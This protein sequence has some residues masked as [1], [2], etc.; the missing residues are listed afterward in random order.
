MAGIHTS[1]HEPQNAAKGAEIRTPRDVAYVIF[2][3]LNAMLVVFLCVLIPVVAYALLSGNTYVSG[4]KVLVRG[5]PES[6]ALASAADAVR[7]GGGARLQEM[8]SELEIMKSRELH[9]QVV[10]GLAGNEDRSPAQLEKA[11]RKLQKKL[12]IELLEDTHVIEVGYQGDDPEHVYTVVSALIDQFFAKHLEVHRTPGAKRFFEE[13]KTE[14]A[15]R[16]KAADQALLEARSETGITDVASQR[17]A[18]LERL[19]AR[20]SELETA[21]GN[22]QALAASEKAVSEL[23]GELPE[24]VVVSSASG[25]ASVPAERLRERLVELK[26][27]EQELA[28]RYHEDTFIVRNMREQIEDVESL[29]DREWQDRREVTQGLNEN[30]RALELSLLNLAS[31]QRALESRI[32][33]LDG[34]IAGLK[35]QIAQLNGSAARIETLELE[36]SLAAQGYE[37]YVQGLEQARIDEALEAGDISNLSLVQAPFMPRLPE[38]PKRLFLLVVGL[39]LA[40]VCAVGAGFLLELVDDSVHTPDQLAGA[41]GL[42]VIASLARSKGAKLPGAGGEEW[43]PGSSMDVTLSALTPSAVCGLRAASS[44]GPVLLA[45]TAARGDVGTSTIAAALAKKLSELEGQRVLLMDGDLVQAT[46]TNAFSTSSEPGWQ[47]RLQDERPAAPPAGGAGLALLPVDRLES[48]TAPPLLDP[49]ELVERLRQFGAG[50]SYVI[51]DLPPGGPLAVDSFAA[52]CDGTLLVAD[53]GRTRSASLGALRTELNRSG[54]R[55]IGTVLNRRE[56]P[57]PD[58]LYRKL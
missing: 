15:S 53:A 20:S 38:G 11:V 24:N 26:L 30:R 36:R 17:A 13:Q 39:L 51:V 16:L 46:L 45:I 37:R 1:Q 23:V 6:S 48:Q 33:A 31:D 22:L 41:L 50:Y 3:R 14:L 47:I 19:G 10:A 58:W 57:V 29:I 32:T 28:D 2:R 27:K 42:P 52:G 18:L 56:F 43:E 44:T 12:R 21:R 5:G 34:T 8:R 4:A 55:V 9:L 40:T 7:D 49:G 25:L 54:V 35:D